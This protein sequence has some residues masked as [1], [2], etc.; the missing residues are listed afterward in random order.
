MV[1]AAVVRGFLSGL[2]MGNANDGVITLSHI[3]F[4]NDTLIFFV[5][6]IVDKFKP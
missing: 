2:S 5:M 6:R 1:E 3:L 4:A